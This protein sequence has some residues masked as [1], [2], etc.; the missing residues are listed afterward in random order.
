MRDQENECSS[1]ELSDEERGNAAVVKDWPVSA[2]TIYGNVRRA[3]TGETLLPPGMLDALMLRNAK[4]GNLAD[5]LRLVKDRLNRSLK[6][7]NT[8]TTYDPDQFRQLCIDAGAPNIFKA[9]EG[10]M[11]APRRNERRRSTIEKLTMNIIRSLCFGLS[12]KCNHLQKDLS[13]FLRTE[14]LKALY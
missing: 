12:Q 6:N 14:N 8:N 4:D 2:V 5:E 13:I 3:P 1:L 11:V 7:A 10:M 9:I